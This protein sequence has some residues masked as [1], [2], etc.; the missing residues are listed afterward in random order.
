MRVIAN[1]QKKCYL[2]LQDRTA[3]VTRSEKEIHLE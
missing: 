1:V 3:T 2:C